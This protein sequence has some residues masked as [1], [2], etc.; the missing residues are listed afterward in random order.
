MAEILLADSSGIFTGEYFFAF[1][2]LA[3]G[4]ENFEGIETNNTFDRFVNEFFSALRPLLQ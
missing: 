4:V 3:G 1:L 2:Y